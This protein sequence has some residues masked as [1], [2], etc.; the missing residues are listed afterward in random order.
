MI[1]SILVK[2]TLHNYTS[3][4]AQN[5]ALCS[6]SHIW[7]MT[8][9]DTFSCYISWTFYL[10]HFLFLR[11]AAYAFFTVSL[12]SSSSFVILFIA[13]I[14]HSSFWGHPWSL[15]HSSSTLVLITFWTCAP[16][17]KLGFLF[18]EFLGPFSWFEHPV[19][20][21]H[22]KAGICSAPMYL[23]SPYSIKFKANQKFI[24]HQKNLQARTWTCI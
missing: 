21:C 2:W 5:H 6:L 15:L 10:S 9:T 7:T 24:L 3:L 16:L 14:P 11:E 23:P 20:L 12:L 18:T 4:F 19:F 1:L 22:S 13:W 8:F 17:A